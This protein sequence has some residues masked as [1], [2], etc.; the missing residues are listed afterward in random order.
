[1]R[2]IADAQLRGFPMNRRA[3]GVGRETLELCSRHRCGTQLLA[4]VL[5]VVMSSAARAELVSLELFE[6]EPFADGA[7]FGDAGSYE[8]IRGL[9]RFA[10]DPDHPRNA[11]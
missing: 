2:L 5:V 8:R 3:G 11:G 4:A 1:M 9:A 7:E 10:V 6:R